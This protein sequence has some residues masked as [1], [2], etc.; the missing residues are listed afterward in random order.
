MKSIARFAS[1]VESLN[2][3][4]QEYLDRL[5]TGET[6]LT[7]TDVVLRSMRPPGIRTANVH[8]Q[9]TPA[10]LGGKEVLYCPKQKLY[11]FVQTMTLP[12]C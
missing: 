5:P 1:V 9:F 2:S 4:P 11:T 12:D 3:R 7:A 6:A 8:V 10:P